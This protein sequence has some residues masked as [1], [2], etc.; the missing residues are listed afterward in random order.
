MALSISQGLAV[1]FNAVGNRKRSAENQWGEAA[2]LREF[3]KQGGVV[4]KDFGYQ[5]EA[6]LDYRRNAGIQ[7]QTSDLQ[8]LNS[9]KTEVL[10]A[11]VYDIAELSAPII[12]SRKDEVQNPTE[13]QKVN[14]V[15]SLASNG[16]DSHDDAVEEGCFATSTNGFLGFG[17]HIT[18]AGTGSSGGIDPSTDT[19]W[20]NQQSTYVDDTDIVAAM[21][22]VWNACAKG[23]G[24]MLS[25][26]LLVSNGATQ[27]L[28]E[29]TQQANQRYV[30]TE[31]LKAGF[32][33]LGFKTSR[34]VFSKNGGTRIFFINPKVLQLW[35]ARGHYR[36]LGETEPLS[37]L[38]NAYVRK[39]YS[40]LQMVG[41]NRS[42][43]GVVHL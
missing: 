1:S 18:D 34:Y 10:T 8:A 14:L 33:V 19:F 36:D 7:F 38:Q 17:T 23:S 11:A 2:F 4:R 40:A 31:E 37:G 20:A 24:S 28:F 3:E 21:T 15:T 25:P 32:K 16:I 35:V 39:V 9:D 22:T 6:T 43:L 5:L 12:W 13:N 41:M 29:G 30:D 42:R 27:A 26:T